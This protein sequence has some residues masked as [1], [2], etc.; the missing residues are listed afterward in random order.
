M[1]R[2]FLVVAGLSWGVVA[3]MLAGAEG[4]AGPPSLPNPAAQRCIEL[5]GIARAAD[6][7][8]PGG[9][10]IGLCRLHDDAVIADWTLFH[11][12]HGSESQAVET[13]LTA[14]WVPMGGP[15]ETWADRSCDAAG[16]RI[17]EYAEHLRPSS[18][19]RVCEFPDGSRI[20][21]WT[22]FAG[23][24]FY[25]L[26]ARVLESAGLSGPN[27][28]SQNFRPCPWP[29]TCMAPCLE[30]APPQ[31]LCR[32]ADGRVE[33]A[34]FA[35]CCCGSGVNAYVPLPAQPIIRPAG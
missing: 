25:P 27:E 4:G 3:G 35:C 16:G 5:G 23:P 8:L 14:H 29:H 7:G 34:S 24:R 17:A 9:G 2:G 15:I 11:A 10:Q 20:E 31:V 18:I 21:A 22:A 28:L 6:A 1:K 19:V 32:F 26:L 30:D 33:P 13:F 12:L